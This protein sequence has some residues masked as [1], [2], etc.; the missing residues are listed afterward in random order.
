MTNPNDPPTPSVGKCRPGDDP[1]R[2]RFCRESS[3]LQASVSLSDAAVQTLK[4]FELWLVANGRWD[5]RKSRSVL[6][7]YAVWAAMGYGL[8]VFTPATRRPGRPPKPLGLHKRNPIPAILR[9][10]KIQEEQEAEAREHLKELI[11]HGD[12]YLPGLEI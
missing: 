3:T 8:S 2:P 4:V 1:R 10:R 9:D 7:E 11:D 12:I 5:Q 6:I